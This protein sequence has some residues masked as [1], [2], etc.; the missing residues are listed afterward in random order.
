[1]IALSL[2]WSFARAC[3]VID[4][5]SKSKR[6]E[7]QTFRLFIRESCCAKK[8]NNQ[9]IYVLAGFVEDPTELISEYGCHTGSSK[10]ADILCL[11]SHCFPI[12]C[13]YTVADNSTDDEVFCFMENGEFPSQCLLGKT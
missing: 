10:L 2:R 13:L 1:M 6:T 7:N 3:S 5:E 9:I 11:L 8:E 12:G 4:K